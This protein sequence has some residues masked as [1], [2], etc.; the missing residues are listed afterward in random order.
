VANAVLFCTLLIFSVEDIR[1]QSISVSWFW[2]LF[3]LVFILV[4]I[5]ASWRFSASFPPWLSIIQNAVSN[6][7]GYSVI[8]DWLKTMESIRLPSFVLLDSFVGASWMRVLCISLCRG[9]IGFLLMFLPYILSKKQ[10]LGEGDIIFFGLLSPLFS[11][12]TIWASYCMTFLLGSIYAI[13][14][15]SLQKFHF[16]RSTRLQKIPLIPF[17]S[18]GFILGMFL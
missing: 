4:L 3:L 1:K 10:G 8:Q 17:I 9:F 6:I 5:P 16:V 13:V 12:A 2:G 15:I 7:T 18:F 14:V 11:V